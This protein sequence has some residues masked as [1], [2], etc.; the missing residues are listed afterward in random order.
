MKVEGILE[1]LPILLLVDSGASHNYIT[2]ELVTSLGLSMI[3]TREFAITL[4]DGSKKVSHGKCE[5]LLI[6]IGQ[7]QLQI[8]AF[9]LEIGGIDIILG[10]DGCKL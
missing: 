10:M 8:N 5:G 9:V 6:T 2:K 1:G 3:D 7:N 4:G